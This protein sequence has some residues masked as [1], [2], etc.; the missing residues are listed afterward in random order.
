MII[1]FW[2]CFMMTGRREWVQLKRA[3]HWT[4]IKREKCLDFEWKISEF[5]LHHSLL[6]QRH[7]VELNKGTVTNGSGLKR[8]P[9]ELFKLNFLSF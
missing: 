4:A 9:A 1:L 8:R 2:K 7:S 3:G 6:M 5:V